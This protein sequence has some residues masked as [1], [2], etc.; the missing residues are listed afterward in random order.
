MVKVSF[1][2]STRAIE[3]RSIRHH[4]AQAL[5]D[6]LV[7][8][9]GS[10][11]KG[12]WHQVMILSVWKQPDCSGW[13]CSTPSG[14]ARPMMAAASGDTRM[15]YGCPSKT[16]QHAG[17]RADSIVHICYITFCT[18]LLVCLYRASCAAFGTTV[19]LSSTGP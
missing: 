18:S 16:T 14:D 17:V 3:H 8:C 2:R 9:R 12:I 19:S 15:S 4:E 1:V 13:R 7:A 5:H 10:D 6:E 11:H